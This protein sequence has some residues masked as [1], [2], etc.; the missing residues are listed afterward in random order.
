MNYSPVTL[1][2]LKEE[3]KKENPKTEEKK[4]QEEVE[5][6][7]FLEIQRNS[8]LSS[9]AKSRSNKNTPESNKSKDTINYNESAKCF[10]KLDLWSIDKKVEDGIHRISEEE[11]CEETQ[12]SQSGESKTSSSIMNNSYIRSR[13]VEDKRKYR[14]ITKESPFW[15]LFHTNFE[16]PLLV[17]QQKEYVKKQQVQEPTPEP[18]KKFKC[19]VRSILPTRNKKPKAPTSDQENEV[20]LFNNKPE[21]ILTKQEMLREKKKEK[22]RK[23]KRNKKEKTKDIKSKP[24]SDAELNFIKLVNDVESDHIIEMDLWVHKY[25]QVLNSMTKLYNDFMDDDD[26][27]DL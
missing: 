3:L 25:S 13:F 18:K 7:K 27:L 4:K 2:M 6:C 20:R 1:N 12:Y 23:Y 5:E 15:M 19:V 22:R 9:R 21:V 24:Q 11:S 26:V 8:S 17:Q 16:N 10:N 14:P